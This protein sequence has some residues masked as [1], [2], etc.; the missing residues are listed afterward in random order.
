MED[1][2]SGAENRDASILLGRLLGNAMTFATVFDAIDGCRSFFFS[3]PCAASSGVE[4]KIREPKIV[5]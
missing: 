1:L 4:G 2:D 5:K 3:E